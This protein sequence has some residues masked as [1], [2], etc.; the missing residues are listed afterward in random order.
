MSIENVRLN[1]IDMNDLTEFFY[2][3]I[4]DIKSKSGKRN[5]K[6]N[7]LFYGGNEIDKYC[8]NRILTINKLWN[9]ELWEVVVCPGYYGDEIDKILLDKKIFN[10]IVDEIDMS[11]FLDTIED[12]VK[13]IL[14]LEYGKVIDLLNYNNFEIIEIDKSEI[15]FTNKNHFE[16]VSKKD[17]KFYKNYPYIYGVVSKNQKKH[18]KN[19][20]IIDGYHR[21]SSADKKTIKV[22]LI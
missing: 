3:Q 22:I 8:I 1:D 19:Y 11:L 14:E 4:V 12:K 9:K 17:L 2:S 21:I 16:I 10:K 18:G 15:E 20:K 6:I 7:T 13:Y 5:E